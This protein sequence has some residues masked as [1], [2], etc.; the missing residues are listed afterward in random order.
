MPIPSCARPSIPTIRIPT[1]PIHLGLSQG[2]VRRSGA[3]RRQAGRNALGIGEA[4]K[5]QGSAGWAETGTVTLRVVSQGQSSA[6]LRMPAG[7]GKTTVSLAETGLYRHAGVVEGGNCGSDWGGSTYPSPYGPAGFGCNQVRYEGW[8]TAADASG[9]ELG[10]AWRS[11]ERSPVLDLLRCL[12]GNRVTDRDRLPLHLLYRFD[13]PGL[14]EVR[15]TLRTGHGAPELRG[16]SSVRVDSHSNSSVCCRISE[17]I[18]GAVK[19]GSK[20]GRARDGI[21]PSV[22]GFPDE[23]SFDIVGPVSVPSL[24]GVRRTR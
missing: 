1:S 18:S 11:L 14:Y 10:A 3:D 15:Y 7:L 24:P 6:A 13:T 23:A 17:E 8:K 21:L 4:D 20:T 9:L 12:P 2:A 16:P 22:F 5:F 19:R